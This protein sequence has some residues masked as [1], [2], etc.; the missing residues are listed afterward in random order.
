MHATAVE[1]AAGAAGVAG[2]GGDGEEENDFLV[3]M[4]ESGGEESGG[5]GGD[6]VLEFDVDMEEPVFDVEV[7]EPV[8]EEE[9][10]MLSLSAS[11]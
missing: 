4:E 10:E 7:E 6:D 1:D 2:A 5:V 9:E 3:E 8:V 11:K